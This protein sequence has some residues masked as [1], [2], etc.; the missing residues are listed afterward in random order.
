LKATLEKQNEQYNNLAASVAEERA[1]FEKKNAK[2]QAQYDHLTA[3]VA[4]E[5]AAFKKEKA[6]LIQRL[7]V[8]EE[9][10]RKTEVAKESF[11]YQ[12]HSSLP[13]R[14]RSRVWVSCLRS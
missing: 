7:T 13:G 5:R 10:N 12:P 6:I 11:A 2:L 3:S 1:E 4:E 8:L 9:S 14:E